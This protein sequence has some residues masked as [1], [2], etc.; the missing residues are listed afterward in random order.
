MYERIN[1]REANPKAV[2]MLAAASKHLSSIDAKLR[3]L[4]ELRVSQI[5]GCVYCVHLHLK[6]ARDEGE[7][8]NRLDAVCV[9]HE[10]NLF[11][12]AERA[13]FAWAEA[14]TNVSQTHAPDADYN[15]LK[16]HYTDQ[17]IVDLTF[18]ISTM[19][20]WNRM[21]VAMRRTADEIL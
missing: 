4:V 14:L 12:E 17:Q 15:A 1:F 2:N 5:N 10:S 6:E 3:A 19:N 20:M 11:T 8:Q 18:I 16:D 13:A 9:W 7:D 21:S